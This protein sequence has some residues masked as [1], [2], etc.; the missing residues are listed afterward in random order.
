[1]S[2]IPQL[3][4]IWRTSVLL[5][6]GA[7]SLGAE[8]LEA[9]VTGMLKPAERTDRAARVKV[10]VRAGKVENTR[11]TR[12]VLSPARVTQPAP[13]RRTARKAAVKPAPKAKTAASKAVKP[14]VKEPAQAKANVR[15]VHVKA[16][17]HVPES[18]SVPASVTVVDG[19]LEG[20]NSAN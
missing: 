5:T 2:V 12:P 20:Q 10:P 15:K 7:I 16:A 6:V 4:A 3:F 19:A 1:M 14:S 9:S 8:Q 13:A 18:V 11:A 17:A